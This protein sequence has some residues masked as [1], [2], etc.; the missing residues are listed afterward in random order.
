MTHALSGPSPRK[1]PPVVTPGCRCPEP[2]TGHC[3]AALSAEQETRA[4]VRA[5]FSSQVSSRVLSAFGSSMSGSHIGRARAAA[6]PA[7]RADGQR[8]SPADRSRRADGQRVDRLTV[9]LRT[10]T[11]SK[12]GSLE[13]VLLARDRAAVRGVDGAPTAGLARLLTRGAVR[14]S[15]PRGFRSARRRWAELRGWGDTP[16]GSSSIGPPSGSQTC[17]STPLKRYRGA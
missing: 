6:R 2:D 12:V 13:R 9:S 1:E 16:E 3:A 17:V 8:V 14:L 5:Q 7:D 11:A 10:S 4:H 15:G